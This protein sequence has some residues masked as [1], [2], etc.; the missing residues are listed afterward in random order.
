MDRSRAEPLAV[1]NVQA[2]IGD[3]AKA[4]RL[5]QNC[6]EHRGE[7]A[8]RRVDDL[9]YLRCRSLLLQGLA[10]LGHQ[11]RILHRDDRLCGEVLQQRNLLVGEWAG[12]LTVNNEISEKCVVFSQRDG[13]QGATT[14]ELNKGAADWVP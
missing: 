11:P 7:I 9:Q 2:S 5:L 14:T 1:I 8:G 10:R 6:L 13:E 3:T 4:V 12:F